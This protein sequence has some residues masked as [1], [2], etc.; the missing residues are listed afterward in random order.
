[1]PNYIVSSLIVSPHISSTALLKF[2]QF[3][4][5]GMTFLAFRFQNIPLL[6]DI[7]VYTLCQEHF[8]PTPCLSFGS[9]LFNFQKSFYLFSLRGSP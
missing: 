3:F 4:P 7:Y 9:L 2:F 6:E 1:M 8:P 5:H